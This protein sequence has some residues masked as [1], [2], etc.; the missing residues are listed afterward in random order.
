MEGKHL[1]DRDVRQLR[2]K[3]ST[4]ATAL[5]I[6]SVAAPVIESVSSLNPQFRVKTRKSRRK[7]V[8]TANWVLLN[9]IHAPGP[10]FVFRF[11]QNTSAKVARCSSHSAWCWIECQYVK[12]EYQLVN[13]LML[14]FSLF[15]LSLPASLYLLSLIIASTRLCIGVVA[16][17]SKLQKVNSVDERN[18]GIFHIL[19]VSTLRHY[20]TCECK[21]TALY[22]C[23]PSL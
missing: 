9:L 21:I 20:E 5:L 15:S 16:L 23:T 14:L 4:S 8:P 10:L 6:V 11:F 7:I 13:T 17:S 19:L 2:K 22:T 3:E 1:P 12:A 18:F